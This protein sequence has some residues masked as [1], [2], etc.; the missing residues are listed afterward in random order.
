MGLIIYSEEEHGSTRAF[1]REYRPSDV[2]QG[3]PMCNWLVL[4][5][6]EDRQELDNTAVAN[7]VEA[8]EQLMESFQDDQLEGAD[9]LDKLY[10][11]AR[12]SG[13]S[14]GKW[15]LFPPEASVDKQWELVCDATASGRLGTSAKVAGSLEQ[16]SFV[17]VV[18]V[19][20]SFDKE[21]VSRVLSE[22][23]RMPGVMPADRPLFYKADIATICGLKAG[24]IPGV[25]A[26]L[27]NSR[28]FE[29]VGMQRS[30]AGQ[31][32]QQQGLFLP[33]PRRQ[34][35]ILYRYPVKPS[36]PITAL[37]SLKIVRALSYAVKH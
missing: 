28:Q 27:Y 7:V 22:L 11:L 20:D 2:F 6:P 17:I 37:H 9:L 19:A 35:R 4:H 5:N 12:K 13:Y 30:R 25:S 3:M 36:A 16:D 8:C 31:D 10:T 24:T 21:E 23:K 15:L 26:T 1:C 18:H 32:E 33:R 29:P 14:S 34:R